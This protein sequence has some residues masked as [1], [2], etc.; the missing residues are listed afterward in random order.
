LFRPGIDVDWHPVTAGAFT[1]TLAVGLGALSYRLVERPALHAPRIQPLWSELSARVTAQGRRVAIAASLT[2]VAALAGLG[3]RLPTSDPIAESLAAGEKVLAAQISPVSTRTPSATT[4]QPAVGKDAAR[5]TA[6][7]R[8]APLPAPAPRPVLGTFKPGSVSVTAIGDSVMVGGAPALHAKLGSSGY[9]DAAKNRRFSE[10]PQIAR[11]LRAQGRLG[12]VVL[13]HLGNNGPVKA[14]E[15]DA[16]MHE[17]KGVQNVLLVTVR[18]NRPWQDSVNDTLRAA[19]GRHR[20]IKIVDWFGFSEGHP[21]WFYS[22]GTHLTKVGAEEYAK[23]LSGSIPPPPPKPTPKPTP[24]PSPTP[25]PD[26]IPLPKVL[27]PPP[28]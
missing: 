8:P 1:T 16:L 27:P 15:V 12:R 26:P 23:L 24:K 9:I 7:H 19:A 6:V 25:T 11:D 18:V 20:S 5:L 2:M 10:A 28:R 4:A 22:D 21:D 17:V 13:V 3:L 14:E